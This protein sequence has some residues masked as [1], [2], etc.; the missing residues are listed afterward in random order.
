M[1]HAT[2]EWVYIGVVISLLTWVGAESWNVERQI[3]HVPAN[4]ETIKVIA[5]QW[6]WTFQHQDGKKEVGQ[7]HVKQNVPY[8]FELVSKDVIHDFNVP[9]FTILMDAVPGRIN[10]VWNMFDKPGEY[11]IQC[12][13]YCGFSHA[14]MRAKLFV[15]PFVQT[16]EAGAA[17]AGG[18]NATAG[19]VQTAPATPPQS[20]GPPGTPLT[21]LSG[22]SV[23]GNPAFDPNPIPVKKGDKITVTNKDTLPHTVTSGT[24]PSDPTSAKSFDT[25]II[26]AG[27]TADIST[28]SLAPGDFPF[29]CTVHPYMT[30]KLTVQ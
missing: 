15:E 13:E 30:G 11:R 14:D 29:Y 6:F 23:Q 22:A 8:K 26:E 10:V 24:G 3:E 16:A 21:I 18:A 4:A 19:N 20:S 7:L 12:R 17:A 27:A 2:V 1:S 28:A 5:Q 25:S 9:E